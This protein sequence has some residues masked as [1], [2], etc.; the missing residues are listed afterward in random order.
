MDKKLLTTLCVFFMSLGF[1]KAEWTYS[2]TLLDLGDTLGGVV[3]GSDGLWQNSPHGVAVA[4]DG[5]VWVNIYGGYG[6][7]EVLASGDT[8]HWK[9]IYVLDPETGEHV[10]F[11]PIETLTFPDGTIDSL[12]AESATSGGG[13]GIEVDG[14]GNILSSHYKSLYKIN[15]M[16]GEGMAMYV[17]PNGSITDAVTDANGNTYV[18]NVGAD[19]P[20]VVLDGNLAYVGNAIDTVRNI[21][22]ALEV[23]ANGEDLYIGSTW[24]GMGISRFSSSVP[25]VIQHAPV[26]TF[27]VLHDVPACFDEISSS[28]ADSAYIGWC[29]AANAD[30]VFAETMMWASSLDFDPD[31]NLLVGCV[32]AAWGGPTGGGNWLF[33]PMDTEEPIAIVGNWHDWDGTGEGVTDGPR[34]AAWDADGDLYL[35]DFYSNGVFHHSYEEDDGFD[36][37][38]PYTYSSTLLDLGDTLGGVVQGSDGLWQNSPHGVAVAP[39]G[40]VWVNIYGGYGEMEVLAS[41][42]TIH[43]KGIYVLD[44]E[45]GEHVSFSPIETLTF[46]D[47]TIDSLTA[48]SATSGGGRGIEVDGDG[49]ILSSHYK[50]LYKINYMTGEGM[51][52]YV[53]PNGS[54]TDAVTD[55]NGNTY[56]GNVGADNPVVVLDGNL[57]YVGNAIDTVRNINRALEVSANGEDL[58]IGSTWNGMGISRFSSSVPGVIQHAPVDTFGVLHDVPACFDEI[59]SS[60]ADSAYIGWCDAANADTVFAETMMW[61]SSLDFDPDGNLLVGCVTAAWGGPTGGGNWL[62]DPM[63]TEEPIAIVGNWHDWDGTGEGVTDGPRGAAWDADGDLYLADFYSNGV[64]L[65]TMDYSSVSDDPKSVVPSGY[66]L[67]QNYPNPFNPN[68]KIEFT[69]PA[70]EHVS[71]NIYN[72]EGRLVKTLIDQEMRSGQHVVRWDGNNQIGTKVATGMYIYQLKTKS[73]VLHRRMTFVK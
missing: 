42:D 21:N 45:T 32:T 20:V 69:I 2:S 30:T 6:E 50:S 16:T 14:D 64:F 57:A 36:I 38:E 68:T 26:D 28:I 12:T 8:I 53:S 9:G 52:M 34:G 54:I 70:S 39:D 23:S 61:A 22:R 73:M 65:Y 17:S 41:G 3:Q 11:S 62:F 37:D 19:N 67:N 29:D 31:G 18:G 7:M 5:N 10:S 13:R 35:A 25:G 71:V 47:G 15:Y 58:Y 60:I 66:V 33:D 46:P 63:D 44:P 27:G 48:E 55:A 72:L 1:V 56:V 40:N 59:S 49:N 51:A 43:W 24:N 4:P